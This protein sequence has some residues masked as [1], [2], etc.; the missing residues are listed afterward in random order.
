M[1]IPV[2]LLAALLIFAY[3]D[4]VFKKDVLNKKDFYKKNKRKR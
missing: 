3:I 4:G 1:W 2:T